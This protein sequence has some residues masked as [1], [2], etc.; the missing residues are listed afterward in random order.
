MLR[1]PYVALLFLAAGVLTAQSTNSSEPK[2]ATGLPQ[3]PNTSTTA[4]A[5]PHPA[6]PATAPTG[7]EPNQPPAAA[8][9]ALS[10]A[11]GA[12]SPASSAQSAE[13]NTLQQ[14]EEPLVSMQ[15][16]KPVAQPK[17]EI[18]DSSATGSGLKTD[19]HDPI[20]DP[21]PPPAGVV[22]LVGG[23]IT[24]VDRVRNRMVVRVF[25]GNHWT[26]NFDERTHIF[27]NGAEVTQLALKKG[28]LVYVDTMLDNNKHDIF[29][30]NIRVGV[31]EVPADADGQI[32]EIDTSRGEMAI[33]DRIN[34]VPVHFLVDRNTRI[35]HGASP[36]NFQDVKQGSLVHV[37]FAPDRPDRGVAREINI[38]ASPG[39]E[40][41]FLGK[42]TYL[43]V[44]RGIL[45]IQN[46]TD[47]RNYTI[48]FDSSRVPLNDLSVGAMVTVIAQF[49]STQY[50]AQSLRVDSPA[51]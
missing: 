48:H 14:T 6:T 39:S 29:A 15:P 17:T 46:Q 32:M 28:E 8:Q 3:T 20:L 10:T 21:P 31:A 35:T 27:R 45:G 34:S 1:S 37:R 22:S 9:P 2:P 13:S 50:T 5:N 42:L 38:I 33:R 12:V 11:P 49:Q 23:M 18:L 51:K 19:G 30:R 43:D 4:P 41:T 40:F 36:A 16:P 26:V 44:H 7:T 24:G 47:D 25:N